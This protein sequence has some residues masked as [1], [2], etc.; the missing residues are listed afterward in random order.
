MVRAHLQHV[1]EHLER[2]RSGHTATPHPE[3][4]YLGGTEG[5]HFWELVGLRL[6]GCPTIVLAALRFRC[7]DLPGI[8]HARES[9][10]SHL[11]FPPA[12]RD[13][14]EPPAIAALLPSA[15]E[16]IPTFLA[17]LRAGRTVA[18]VHVERA[19]IQFAFDFRMHNPWA[20]ESVRRLV[21]PLR[22]FAFR[23]VDGHLIHGESRS[24]RPALGAPDAFVAVHAP[25]Q[26]VGE[27]EIPLPTLILNRSYIG[28]SV[29]ITDES[30]RLAARTWVPFMP[31]ASSRASLIPEPASGP[32]VAQRGNG[33]H[34]AGHRV[35]EPGHLA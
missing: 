26:L 30:P 17:S 34:A 13:L 12:P 19:H 27:R 5:D 14:D 20:V 31:E 8:E 29:D 25:A 2:V 3:S 33:V 11:S 1:G 7:H 15:R 35:C 6:V 16:K 22:R 28:L 21:G 23:T 32:S 9:L 18:P 24:V 4:V 10:A